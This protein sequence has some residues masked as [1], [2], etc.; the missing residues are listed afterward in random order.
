MFF[1]VHVGKMMWVVLSSYTKM[2]GTGF[3]F[4]DWCPTP[5]KEC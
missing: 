1:L 5:D 4:E 3:V 2:S